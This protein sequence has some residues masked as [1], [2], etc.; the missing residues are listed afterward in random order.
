MTTEPN[1]HLSSSDAYYI[2][3]KLGDGDNLIQR[4][5]VAKLKEVAKA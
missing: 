5:L 2:L 3:N 1:I 4:N